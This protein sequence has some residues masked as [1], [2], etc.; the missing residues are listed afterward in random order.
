MFI[1][2]KFSIGIYLRKVSSRLSYLT[3]QEDLKETLL[4]KKSVAGRNG[5]DINIRN[6]F[7]FRSSF[8]TFGALQLTVF[9][10][11]F[12]LSMMAIHYSFVIATETSI[13]PSTFLRTC[14]IIM[15]Y[16]PPFLI[17]LILFPLSLSPFCI[18]ASVENKTSQHGIKATEKIMKKVKHE[19]ESKF[20]NKYVVL[21]IPMDSNDREDAEDDGQ[22][23]SSSSSSSG[24]EDDEIDAQDTIS[25][26]KVQEVTQT[27]P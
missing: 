20:S 3:S 2:I 22:V 23:I 19:M 15:A 16:V 24:E 10:Q 13:H 21:D 18:L 11:S 7:V 26:I 8:F 9:F 12:Y 27:N 6:Y 4:K 5:Q 1:F 14:I 17:C 25:R